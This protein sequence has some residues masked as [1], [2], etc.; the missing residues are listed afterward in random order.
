MKHP[1]LCNYNGVNGRGAEERAEESN[2][3]TRDIKLNIQ[4]I[5][6]PPLV[7]RSL[8]AHRLGSG[9]VW[10]RHDQT[11]VTEVRRLRR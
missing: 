3:P 8:L 10:R 11:R 7:C 2:P 5:T 9:G 1:R 4:I 6:G